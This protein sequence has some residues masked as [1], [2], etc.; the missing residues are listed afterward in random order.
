MVFQEARLDDHGVLLEY[1]LPLTSRRLDC[2][3]TGKGR[4]PGLVRFPR[5]VQ[6]LR[7]VG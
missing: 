7:S 4:L 1:Q 6:Q 2:I 5:N 3:V